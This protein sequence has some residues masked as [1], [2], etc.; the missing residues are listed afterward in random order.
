MAFWNRR[1][2]PLRSSDGPVLHCSFCNKSQQHVAKLIT[3]PPGHLICSECLGL[4]NAILAEDRPLDPG[5]P[6]PLAP[7]LARVFCSVCVVSVPVGS[8]VS[9][10]ERGLICLACCK[11]IAEAFSSAGVSA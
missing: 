9:V 5:H 8:T 1:R 2:G 3:G 7:E 4:C 6:R 10:P 11:V